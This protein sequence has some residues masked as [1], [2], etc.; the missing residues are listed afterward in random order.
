V[1][2]GKQASATVSNLL[3]SATVET[4]TGQ[5]WKQQE[6]RFWVVGLGSLAYRWGTN[7]WRSAS[8]TNYVPLG[9]N[10]EFQA[11]PSPTESSWPAGKPT[12]TGVEG[13]GATVSRMFT[14]SGLQE[15]IAECGNALTARVGVIFIDI[16]Q[17]ETNVPSSLTTAALTLTPESYWAEAGGGSVI[18]ESSPTG[19]AV[20]AAGNGEF[21]FNPSAS[22]PTSFVVRA[23]SSLLPDQFDTCIVRIE[24]KLINVDLDGQ[25]KLMPDE[26]KD[27]DD[28]KEVN[29]GI[30]LLSGKTRLLV[31]D[32][33]TNAGKYK[34][35]WTDPAPN[36]HLRLVGPGGPKSPIEV[37]CTGPWPKEYEVIAA[38]NWTAEDA[39]EV[40]L[41][42]SLSQDSDTVKLTGLQLDLDADINMDGVIDE[43]DDPDEDMPGK[44]GLLVGVNNNTHVI[45]GGLTEVDSADAIINGADDQNNDLK[46]LKLKVKSSFINGK[47]ILSCADN[48]VVR[49]FN[50]AGTAVI[51]P[52]IGGEHTIPVATVPSGGLEYRVEAIEGGREATVRL[53]YQPADG[54]KPINDTVK[55]STVGMSTPGGYCI[56]SLDRTIAKNVLASSGKPTDSYFMGVK[57]LEYPHHPVYVVVN[58]QGVV[59]KPVLDG[60]KQ[61][62]YKILDTAGT[63]PSCAVP[64]EKSIRND[65]EFIWLLE[66]LNTYYAPPWW[67]GDILLRGILTAFEIEPGKAD[68]YW[69]LP[70]IYT[71]GNHGIVIQDSATGKIVKKINIC[72]LR[73][74]LVPNYDRDSDIDEDDQKKANAGNKYYF[75]INNDDDKSADDGN[76]RPGGGREDWRD[77][78]WMPWLGKYVVDSVRDLVDFFPM[79]VDIKDALDVCPALEYDYVLKHSAGAFNAFLNPGLTPSEADKHLFNKTFCESN[80]NAEL[81]HIKASGYALSKAFLDAIKNDNKGLVLLEARAA[82]Q[83]PLV[84]EIKKKSDGTVICTEEM[85]VSIDSVEKMFR[86]KN[87]RSVSGGSGGEPDRL[88]EPPN[89][90]DSL[91]INK[92]FVFIHGYNV[93]GNAAHASQCEVF[94]RMYWSGSKAKFH[95][96]SWRGDQTQF[97]L[98]AMTPNYH[99][100]VVNAFNTAGDLKT[101]LNG[102]R[103]NASRELSKI[104]VTL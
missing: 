51:G 27:V 89:Y 26:W 72:V 12:W 10:V 87:L 8:G 4:A 39:I 77:S 64:L 47:L 71:T 101:Y 73:V 19:L 24:K 82:T 48:S 74:N 60:L 35:T 34:L 43:G 2:T 32:P 13:S 90:P 65:P 67:T 36:K 50:E 11:S 29:P 62:T 14:A 33:G 20:V 52:G 63:V 44:P 76:D 6:R 84:L 75:W 25:E 56:A 37:D 42:H 69:Q 41:T 18:W 57:A 16:A 30:L 40:T 31:R 96:I 55:V 70:K 61:G 80:A 5:E 17:T 100:N 83:A 103:G 1:I 49:I 97:P 85:K 58:L 21:R 54:G 86:H 46:I 91:T 99:I 28:D 92:N 88:G 7:D 93:D 94:K 95:G 22:Q 23:A 38:G 3:L 68:Y 9:T 15:V 53:E 78:S 79:W 45:N 66:L 98:I 81:E 104:S 102:L 59:T